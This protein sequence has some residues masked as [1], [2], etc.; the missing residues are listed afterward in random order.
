MEMVAFLIEGGNLDGHDVGLH[1]GNKGGADFDDH[2]R[3]GDHR[4]ELLS[5]LAM[6]PIVEK[7][8]P[9]AEWSSTH[10]WKCS[11]PT[12]ISNPAFSASTAWRTGCSGCHCSCPQKWAN[13]VVVRAKDTWDLGR[14][15]FR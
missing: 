13:F 4:M 9:D 5:G 14:R 8:Q 7:A 3:R 15:L 6:A 12:A 2:V 11:E 10:G 1:L